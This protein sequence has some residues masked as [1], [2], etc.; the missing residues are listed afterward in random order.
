MIV[1]VPHPAWPAEAQR[2]KES[3][4]LRE[5]A[6]GRLLF[7]QWEQAHAGATM[8]QAFGSKMAARHM[9]AADQQR[10]AYRDMVTAR[11]ALEALS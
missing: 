5:A 8:T 3:E 9:H 10:R 4:D 7:A 1:C 6:L 2:L 11:L